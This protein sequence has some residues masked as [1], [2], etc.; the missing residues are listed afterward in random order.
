MCRKALTISF[1]FS[2]ILAALI[3]L[4]TFENYAV[5]GGAVPIAI[6]FCYD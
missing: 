3:P 1:W 5:L 4:L 2:S 6:Y